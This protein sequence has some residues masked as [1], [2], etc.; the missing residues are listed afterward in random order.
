[1]RGELA[2]A[3]GHAEKAR[4]LA[5]GSGRPDFRIDAMSVLAYTTLYFGRLADARAWIERCLDLYERERGETLRYPVPQDAKT[6]ALA[7][8]P[9]VAW[10]LGDA[11]GA[12]AAVATGLAHVNHLERDFD[13]A[14]LHAWTAGTR[15]TQRRYG[16]SLQHAMEAMRLGH[17]HNFQ[18]W[19]GVGGMMTLLCQAAL[20]PKPELV[21]AALA[22][23]QAFGERR[24][25]LNASYYLWGIA[26]GY[27]TAGRFDQ[28]SGVLQAALA[29]AA[30]SGETRMNP[31]LW[32]LQAEIEP[33]PTRALTLLVDAFELAER[34]GAVANA[35]RAA[36]TIVSRRASGAD[37]D[38]ARTTL[39]R[40]DGLLPYPD[41]PGWM[42]NALSRTG[43][44]VRA[45]YSR[46]QGL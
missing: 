20:E 35:L 37:H 30:A 34:Q 6:A 4:E 46:L 32:M 43:A 41:S 26:R 18:E 16:E 5:E 12:D 9:T 45:S 19:K 22:T 23:A 21:D 25:G 8:L 40:L 28:A 1:V 33:D 44:A 27:V 17:D 15:Y 11:H 7:L 14:L 3:H 29:A 36:A 10:L 31:E 13:K 38:D 2:T 24:V 42:Q 39:A